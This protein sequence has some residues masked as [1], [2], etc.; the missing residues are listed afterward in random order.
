[1]ESLSL[2][3]CYGGMFKE[4]LPF[5][6][7]RNHIWIVAGEEV[8]LYLNAWFYAHAQVNVGLVWPRS[9]ILP[10]RKLASGGKNW[11]RSS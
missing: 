10:T 2:V 1:M 8:I 7:S 9:R 3:R 6:S 4:H 11:F 5:N